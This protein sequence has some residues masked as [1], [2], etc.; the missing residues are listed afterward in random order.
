MTE[1]TTIQVRKDQAKE[2]QEIA[3]EN[4]NYKTAIDR[5]IEGYNDTTTDAVDI[6]E[7]V[8]RFEELPTEDMHA[9]QFAKEVAKHLDYAEISHAVAKQVANELRQ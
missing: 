3:R 6:D 9:D 5:L 2:L 4:G 8:E 1:T 7:I